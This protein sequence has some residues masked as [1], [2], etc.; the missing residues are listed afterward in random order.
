[1]H[2]KFTNGVRKS[3]NTLYHAVKQH[4]AEMLRDNQTQ[5]D[6]AVFLWSEKKPA[7]SKNGEKMHNLLLR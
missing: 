5:T 3:A 6:D 2:D 4:N 1:M 7:Q